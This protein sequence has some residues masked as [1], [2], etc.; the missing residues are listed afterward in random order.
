MTKKYANSH[1]FRFLEAKTF[2]YIHNNIEAHRPYLVFGFN[3]FAAYTFYRNIG[4]KGD[5]LPV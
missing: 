1:L 5:K 4:N 3:L 2:K